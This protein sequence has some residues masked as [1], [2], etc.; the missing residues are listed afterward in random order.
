MHRRLESL[1]SERNGLE[2]KLEEQK[3]AAGSV[4][5]ELT[6]L[7]AKRERLNKQVNARC[8]YL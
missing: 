1:E 4:Q 7:K 3:A 5:K 6:D 2:T 8:T